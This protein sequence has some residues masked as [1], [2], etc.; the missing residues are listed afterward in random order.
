[1]K[2]I[3]S[4]FRGFP[5]PN[6]FPYL[7]ITAKKWLMPQFEILLKNLSSLHAIYKFPHFGIIWSY[8][9]L[10]KIHWML[11]VTYDWRKVAIYDNFVTMEKKLF[12]I[13]HDLLQKPTKMMRM[14]HTYAAAIMVSLSWQ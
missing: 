7:E 1:M 5:Y 9:Y 11:R 13:F 6:E 10:A 4:L 14:G 2:K 12:Q 3:L 8:D